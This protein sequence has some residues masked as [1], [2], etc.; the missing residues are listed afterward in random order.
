MLLPLALLYVVAA[1]VILALGRGLLVLL[2]MMGIESR[3]LSFGIALVL[4]FLIAPTVVAGHGIGFLPWILSPSSFGL[5][6]VASPITCFIAWLA[7]GRPFPRDT[8]E[9]QPETQSHS[10]ELKSQGR[11][12][13]VLKFPNDDPA[14]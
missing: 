9:S 6:V 13:P 12:S 1:A 3:G 11:T 8:T 5:G 7:M 10:S 4:G 2:R 14:P